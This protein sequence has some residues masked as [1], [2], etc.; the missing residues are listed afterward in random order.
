MAILQGKAKDK[1]DF[2][3]LDYNP[4][5]V[6]SGK[7]KQDVQLSKYIISH[8]ENYKA[9]YEDEWCAVLEVK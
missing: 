7:I 9:A 8:K 5:Y 3:V 6:F 1:E 4:D 2:I